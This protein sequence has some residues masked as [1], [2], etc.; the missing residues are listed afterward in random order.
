[1]SYI[2]SGPYL[3]NHIDGFRRTIV[4]QFTSLV[5]DRI[6]TPTQETKID[7]RRTLECSLDR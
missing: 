2:G 7:Q 3:N 1:M 6:P 5:T 4:T